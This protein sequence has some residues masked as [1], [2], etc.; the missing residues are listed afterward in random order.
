MRFLAASVMVGLLASPALALDLDQA[1][2]H[3]AID[4]PTDAL[5]DPITFDGNPTL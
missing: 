5:G 1:A 2:I 4:A 3:H